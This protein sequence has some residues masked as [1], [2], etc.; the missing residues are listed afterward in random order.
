[1]A[2]VNMCRPSLASCELLRPAPPE[3]AP[4]SVS[5]LSSEAR[6]VKRFALKDIQLNNIRGC[7]SQ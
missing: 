6:L 5:R 1:M 7:H 4:L 2:N 3:Q